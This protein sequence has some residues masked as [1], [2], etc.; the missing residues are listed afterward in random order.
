MNL[1]NGISTKENRQSPNI[2]FIHAESMDGRKMG[3]MGEPALQ[4]ATPNLDA[5][6]SNGTLFT[7]AY[8][9]CPVCN[10]SRASMWSGKYPH[11]YE[12]WNN[13]EGIREHR[14]TFRTIF[15]RLGY[16][17]AAIGPLD[18]TYD[19]HSVRDRVGSWTRAADIRRKIGNKTRMPAVEED[20]NAKDWKNMYEAIDW[21]H[22][23]ADDSRPFMLY[24]T[25]G[26]VHPEFT[27]PGN[28]RERIDPGKIKLPPTLG[29][30][31]QHPHPVD[32]YMRLTKG[33][34]D[35][36]PESLVREMRR[37]YCAMIAELDDIV[38]RIR[39]TLQELGVSEST[40]IIFSSD[41]GEMAGEQN[42]IL[43]RSMY[44]PSIHVP[45]MVTGPDVQSSSV[46]ET[47]VSLVDIFPTLMD[48]AGCCY[49]DF[50]V[51]PQYPAELDGESL[52]PQLRGE[53]A[54][55]R[56]WAFAE[57]HGDRNCTGTFMLRQGP[58]KYIKHM[59]YKPQ[60][61]NLEEDPW[62]TTDLTERRHDVVEEMD[63]LMTDRF[64]CQN[65][66]AA[67]KSYDKENF[68]KWRSEQIEKGTYE[69]IMSNIYS[70]FGRVCIE[71]VIPWREEDEEKIR[72][73]L[74]ED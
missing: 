18:Y 39:Q 36:Y 34:E 74:G 5:L 66:D 15:N 3:C 71:D 51:P 29:E 2:V 59:G 46:V 16:N 9:N 72:K 31:D 19:M 43:K 53:S 14:P 35:R 22:E 11:Y 50:A 13:C 26:L 17:T 68:R 4:G 70:G 52:M 56:D 55:R 54:E 27:A 73:W 65:I 58:W 33:C 38:G 32:Q 6:A 67:A 63:N 40:Y 41:H 44:E 10:P 47:P 42:Q 37:M 28:Y 12:N 62:E 1:S 24:F 7:N 21:L 23:A 25:T 57:Y 20:A 30:L 45:L 69:A 48:M 61:F 60:L 64:D 8:S 49:E